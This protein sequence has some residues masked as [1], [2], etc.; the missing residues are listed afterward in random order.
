MEEI[1]LA[2]TCQGEV[3]LSVIKCECNFHFAVDESL[4]ENFYELVSIVC[5]ICRNVITWEWD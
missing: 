3:F 4:L 5:P 2:A 1:G